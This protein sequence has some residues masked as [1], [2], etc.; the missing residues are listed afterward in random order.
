MLAA[1][2]QWVVFYCAMP[3]VIWGPQYLVASSRRQKTRETTCSPYKCVISHVFH[4]L[5]YL[6]LALLQI[7]KKPIEFW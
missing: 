2:E 4:T 5:I 3:E 1:I 7:L 6:E